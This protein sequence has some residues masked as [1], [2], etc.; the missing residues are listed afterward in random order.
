MI[1]IRSSWLFF[2]S[3]RS[4][5]QP[6][7]TNHHSWSQSTDERNQMQ[8]NKHCAQLLL[9]ISLC[10]G[11]TK[12]M[13]VNPVCEWLLPRVYMLTQYVYDCFTRVFM[14]YPAHIWLFYQWSVC[15]TKYVYVLLK[16]CVCF[17]GMCIIFF[18]WYIFYHG[19]VSFTSGMYILLGV[20][21]YHKSV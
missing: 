9:I 4:L 21:C 11:H 7:P 14:F 13:Y 2:V 17:T 1:I 6:W 18:K 12:G 20:Y 8:L 16:I 5:Q 15:F 10:V 3:R 19:Y